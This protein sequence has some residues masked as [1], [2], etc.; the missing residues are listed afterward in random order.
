[1]LKKCIVGAGTLCVQVRGRRM[2]R[3]S[4]KEAHVVS[5]AVE[6]FRRLRARFPGE[7]DSLQLAEADREVRDIVMR[8]IYTGRA[9]GAVSVRFQNIG[10]RP[11]SHHLDGFFVEFTPLSGGKAEALGVEDFL[12]IYR[13]FAS[14]CA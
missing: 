9:R 8:G 2:R 14:D 3:L 11:G 4:T 7:L 1:M 5:E 10:C 6:Q 13:F 12:R